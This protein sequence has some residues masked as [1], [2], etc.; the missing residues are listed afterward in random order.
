MA[1]KLEGGGLSISG[2]TLFFGFPNQNMSLRK[3]TVVVDLVLVTLRVH[4]LLTGNKY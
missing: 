3:C 2:G 1:T 4:A